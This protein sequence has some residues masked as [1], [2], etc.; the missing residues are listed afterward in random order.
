MARTV[1]VS[2][3]TD[4][5]ASSALGGAARRSV[6][7]SG[8]TET[9][10]RATRTTRTT[11][12]TDEAPRS[13][14]RGRTTRQG[15][16]GFSAYKENVAETKREFNTFKVEKETLVIAFLE[17]EPFDHVFRH[18]IQ[19]QPRNCIG[20]ECPVCLRGDTPKAVLLFNVV[21]MAHPDKV[22][23]WEA[24]AEPVKRIE[25]RYDDL[26][27]TKSGPL[28]LNSPGVYFEVS[29][30]KK[31]NGYTEYTVDRL[32]ENI[33]VDEWEMEPLT[34][35]D[36]E[37]LAEDLYTSDVIKYNTVAELEEWLDGLDD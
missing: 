1:R 35:E 9:R 8:E 23:L 17:D 2:G 13:E 26:A 32:Y 24:S 4:N 7:S 33:L 5:T 30:A 10:G 22:L 28:K 29:K 34:D 19:R 6:R 27:A 3:R 14:S 31:S 20:D 12:E 18:W 15:G 11:R 36:R 25:K 16:R 21:N 37:A